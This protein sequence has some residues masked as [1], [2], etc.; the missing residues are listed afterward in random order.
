MSKHVRVFVCFLSIIL[1]L[2]SAFPQPRP[3]IGGFDIEKVRRAVTGDTSLPS[4][5]SLHA[6]TGAAPARGRENWPLVI[7]R[8]ALYLAIT[9]GATFFVVWGIKRLG[10]AGRSKLRG[11]SMDVLEAVALG[12]NKSLALVRVVDKVYLVGQTQTQITLLDTMEGTKAIELI[13]SSKG[14]VSIG[15]FKDVFNSFM[16]R[17]KAK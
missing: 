3:D 9:A 7:L 14:G 13:A 1:P 11:G 17:F 16:D 2:C 4:L 12:Q 6:A 5:D 10:L 15:Q 8:I